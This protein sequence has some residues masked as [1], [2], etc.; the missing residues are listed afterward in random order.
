M[1]VYLPFIGEFGWYILLFVKKFNADH[2]NDKMICCKKG[3][4]CLFPTAKHFFYDWQDVDDNLKAGVSDH[5]LEFIVKQKIM[6]DN[7]KVNP[8]V[9]NQYKTIEEFVYLSDC[10]WHNKN[11][12]S[13][14]VFIPKPKYNNN[15]NVD[16]VICPRNRQVD[17]Y[18]NW[19]QENWQLI[20][21][22]LKKR[23]YRV[24]LCGSKNSSFDLN[25]LDHKS[26]DYVD[27]DS[28]V[29]MMLSAKL[30]IGQESG[31]QYLSFLCERPTFCI[32][33]Y[34]KDFGS[35]L[36]RP[37]H[38]PFKSLEHLWDDPNEILKEA[39]NFLKGV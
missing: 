24:G 9:K 2:H 15:L 14:S 13:D 6:I 11:N 4:E 25:N 3:H 10:G 5:K 36:H 1:K 33:H 19:K 21:D 8:F 20:I 22:G 34:H 31:L 27:V 37:K 23:G 16:V 30:V 18:R 29:E 35:D 39:L 17:S 7:S 32:D 38:V 26:Y 12:F 28:D